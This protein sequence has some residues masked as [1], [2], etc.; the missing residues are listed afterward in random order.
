M[1]ENIEKMIDALS[2]SDTETAKEQF[3]QIMSSKKDAAL[4]AKKVAVAQKIYK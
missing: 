4:E 1:K 3:E 2:A